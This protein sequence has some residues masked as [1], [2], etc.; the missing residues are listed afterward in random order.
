MKKTLKR[1]RRISKNNLDTK[2]IIFRMAIVSSRGQLTIPQD[3]RALMHISE[4]SAVGF[5]PTKRGVLMRPMKVEPENPYTEEEWNKIE[6][7]S[8]GKGKI[9][10]TVEEAKRHIAD[11]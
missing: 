8:K 7:L 4:G 11:L 9:Y 10:K 2:R 6:K 5:E 1:K 3:I